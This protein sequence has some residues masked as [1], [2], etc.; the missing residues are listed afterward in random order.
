M[1]IEA[2]SAHGTPGWA[3]FCER[4]LNKFATIKNKKD[5]S[6]PKPHWGKVNKDWTPG[7]G[8]YTKQAMGPQLARVKEAVMKMDPTGMFRNKHLSEVFDMPY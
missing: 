3:E 8:E 1:L 6:L 4:V 7:I 5:G 2:S